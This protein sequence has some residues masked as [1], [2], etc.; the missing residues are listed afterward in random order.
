MGGWVVGCACLSGWLFGVI[1]SYFGERPNVDIPWRWAVPKFFMKN[2]M[3]KN[4]IL[5]NTTPRTRCSVVAVIIFR[6]R[7][8]FSGKSW[9]NRKVLSVKC[10]EERRANTDRRPKH[11]DTG[12]AGRVH[13][14]QG[15]ERD[16]VSF[17]ACT[18]YA[19]TCFKTFML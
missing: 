16:L 17:Y 15:Y 6:F 9:A 2:W 11:I 8:K 19:G 13:L 4:N 18:L 12:A 1:Q 7:F 10:T 3:P 14:V 5:Q